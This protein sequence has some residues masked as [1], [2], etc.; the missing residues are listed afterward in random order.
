[1]SSTNIKPPAS[2]PPG[3]SVTTPVVS[4][5][6][7]WPVPLAPPTVSAF[8]RRLPSPFDPP[9]RTI[10]DLRLEERRRIRLELARHG[11]R[12]L[13]DPADEPF[14]LA[15]QAVRSPQ[16]LRTVITDCGL[17]GRFF[18]FLYPALERLFDFQDR[19]P[20]WR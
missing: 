14:V 5:P 8:V 6:L 16:E 10:A 18:P 13:T 19:R 4:E 17:D 15:I 11:G 20:S 1:M 9:V 3:I 2:C 7:G 12:Y